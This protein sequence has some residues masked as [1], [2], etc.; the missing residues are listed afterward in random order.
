LIN[1]S[2][3]AAL[4]IDNRKGILSFANSSL[5]K[6]TAF[7]NAELVGIK[8]T[9][10]IPDISIDN[11]LSGECHEKLL[12]RRNRDPLPVLVR[13]TQ[14]DSYNQWIYLSLTPTSFHQKKE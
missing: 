14:L 2:H 6:L 5:S 1:I 8:L 10:L 7:S 12:L 11:V 13:G 3:D 4:I 9:E